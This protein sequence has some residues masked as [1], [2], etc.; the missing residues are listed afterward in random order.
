MVFI[1]EKTQRSC[2]TRASLTEVRRCNVREAVG[3]IVL[4][5]SFLRLGDLA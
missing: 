1:R 5:R 4:C 3:S 2:R